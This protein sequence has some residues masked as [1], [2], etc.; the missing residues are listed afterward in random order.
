MYKKVSDKALEQGLK[1][2]ESSFGKDFAI[3]GLHEKEYTAIP[4]TYDELDFVLTKGNGGIYLGG[5]CELYGGESGGK[6][7]L[8][9]RIVGQ[10]QKM[11]LHCAWFDAEHS[12][13]P[14]LAAFNGVD[15]EKLVYMNRTSGSGENATLLDAGEVLNRIFKSV[16]TNVFSVIVLDSVAALMSERVASL[17]FDPTKKG[18]GELPREMS[19]QL[20]KIAS[21][22]DEKQCTVICINQIREKIGVMYGDPYDTPGGKALKFYANQ[23]IGLSKVN[24][25]GGLVYQTDENGIE[26]VVGHY[27]RVTIKKNRK[28]APFFDPLEI[29]IYYKE[30]FP[31]KAKTC[32]DLA[33]KLQVITTRRGILTWKDPAGETVAQLEGESNM[34]QFIRG[35]DDVT[36]NGDQPKEAYLAYCCVEVG[37]DEK[38]QQKKNPTRIPP[39]I[40]K[41]ANEYI[42]N[43]VVVSE[44]Q[45]K[46][47]KGKRKGASSVDQAL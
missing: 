31:D 30:Y 39:M 11:G 16:W 9:M 18:M 10:A 43:S 34:L 27:A 23:R 12:F 37:K 17:D 33:R 6:S 2:L 46:E 7:S 20:A 45:P 41:L 38:Q 44:E 1:L 19:L 28:N 13:S 4:T 3:K 22:C 24:G 35:T 29:P 15:I 42:P 40:E 36:P 8:A 26:E 47:K 32:Y 5:L 14:D 21:A 25:K